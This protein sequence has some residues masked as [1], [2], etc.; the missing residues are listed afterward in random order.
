MA[1]HN[2]IRKRSHDDVTFTKFNRN[3]NFVPN[4][5]ARSGSHVNYSPCRMDF[6]CDGI[7]DNL[8]EQ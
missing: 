7:V 6:V 2:Y 3:P 4:I 8:M 5:I 1:Q